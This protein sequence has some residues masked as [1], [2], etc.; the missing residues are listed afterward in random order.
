[1]TQPCKKAGTSDSSVDLPEFEPRYDVSHREHEVKS[2]TGTQNTRTCALPARFRMKSRGP[3]PQ[4]RATLLVILLLIAVPAPRLYFPR[5][6]RCLITY[7][8]MCS[9]VSTHT[10]FA[11]SCMY[12]QSAAR[13]IVSV[14]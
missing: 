5:L 8:A 7:L 11:G 4:V 2:R 6:A 10:P 3:K 14:T 9:T 12:R 13:A 1:M